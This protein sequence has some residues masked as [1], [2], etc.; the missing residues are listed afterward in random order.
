MLRNVTRLGCCASSFSLLGRAC[1]LGST[2]CTMSW[3]IDDVVHV[4]LR[5]ALRALLPPNSSCIPSADTLSSAR[6][7][8]PLLPHLP[9]PL[10]RRR[11][12]LPRPATSHKAPARLACSGRLFPSV[13]SFPSLLCF[14][15]L[16]LCCL[17]WCWLK[18]VTSC[19]PFKNGSTTAYPHPPF[20]TSSPPLHPLSTGHPKRS[21]SQA[22]RALSGPL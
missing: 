2:S 18:Q 5:T 4:L 10:L 14:G 6:P 13:P 20:P 17:C 16:T 3:T 1:L 12:P 7:N 19:P 8:R 15:R 11:H 22:L 21:F 9:F